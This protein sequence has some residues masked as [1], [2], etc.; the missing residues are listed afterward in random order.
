MYINM[1]I[2]IYAYMYKKY[3]I[4]LSLLVIFVLYIYI[5]I[6]ITCFAKVGAYSSIPWVARITTHQF[7][8]RGLTHPEAVRKRNDRGPNFSTIATEAMVHC[9]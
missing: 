8:A 5:Y 1:H 4:L 3:N 9:R 2:Y 6:Y 7:K